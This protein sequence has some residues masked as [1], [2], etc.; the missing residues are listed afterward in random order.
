MPP[1][2]G[3]T[4]AYGKEGP[5]GREGRKS[6]GNWNREQVNSI[7]KLMSGD[8]IGDCEMC[9]RSLLVEYEGTCWAFTCKQC[10][11]VVCSSCDVNG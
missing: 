9:G 7:K 10:G 11:V 6:V 5:E 8:P 2:L 4:N 3:R 1:A